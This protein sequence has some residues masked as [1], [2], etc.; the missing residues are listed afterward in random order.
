MGSVITPGHKRTVLQ[1]ESKLLDCRGFKNG[2]VGL[3][4]A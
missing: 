1:C 2:E 3:K 4:E